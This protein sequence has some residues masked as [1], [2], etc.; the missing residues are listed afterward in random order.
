MQEYMS[1]ES[2][3]PELN[4]SDLDKIVKV[5]SLTHQFDLDA[6]NTSIIDILSDILMFYTTLSSDPLI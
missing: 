4:W 6:K 3:S 2:W 1:F 5:H